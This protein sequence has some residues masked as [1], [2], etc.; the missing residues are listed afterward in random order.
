MTWA[1]A[2]TIWDDIPGIGR[3]VAE[4][5]VVGVGIEMEQLESAAPPGELGQAQPW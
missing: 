1:E 2:I 5:I 4:E 3:R